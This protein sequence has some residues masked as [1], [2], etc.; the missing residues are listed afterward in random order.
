MFHQSH[1]P[2][3]DHVF[4]SVQMARNDIETMTDRGKMSDNNI[5]RVAAQLRTP[6]HKYRLGYKGV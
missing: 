1:L 4:S 6:P 2:R 5:S 3:S